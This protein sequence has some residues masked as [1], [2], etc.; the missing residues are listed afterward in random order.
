ER[1][2]LAVLDHRGR[3]ADM[4]EADEA[5]AAPRAEQL[6]GLWVEAVPFVGPARGVA[7]RKGG[8]TEVEADIAGREQLLHLGGLGVGPRRQDHADGH[9]RREELLAL[10]LE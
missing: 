7:H 6:F 2:P 9:R 8:V 1:G 4:D 5:L 3:R 10:D